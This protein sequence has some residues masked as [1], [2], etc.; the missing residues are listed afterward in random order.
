M[1]ISLLYLL[2]WYNCTYMK[3]QSGFTVVEI[4]VAIVL[5]IAAGVLFLQQKS[6]IERVD[7]DRERKIAINAMYYSLEEVYY[8]ANKSYPS[9]LTADNLKSMDPALLKDPDGIKIGDQGS[10]YRYD[11]TGCDGNACKNFT[12]RATLEA[13]ADFVKKSNR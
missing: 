2:Q 13:E 4:L 7:R 12:L 10:N 3:K 5:I 9:K 8:T 1:F 6:Q 11:P